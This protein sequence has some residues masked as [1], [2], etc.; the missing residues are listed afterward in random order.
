MPIL[1]GRTWSLQVG[2]LDLTD[3]DFTF[4]VERSARREPNRAEI[5]IWNLNP[6]TRAIV[7]AG[8][9]VALRCG[10]D[11]D[12]PLLF[13]GDSRWVWT[14]REGPDLITTI[15]ARDGGR[16]YSEARIA[17]AYNPGTSISTI[18]EDLIADMDIGR[19]NLDEV[20]AAFQLRTG[21][22]TVPDG[23]VAAGPCRR[24]LSDL[25]RGAGLRWSVQNGALQV[26]RGG[27]PLQ[28]TAIVLAAD[29]GLL[30]VPTW[31]ERGHR[32]R[33]RRGVLTAKSLLQP[34]TE[35]GRKVRVETALVEGDFE[36][37][38]GSYAGGTR[39]NDWTAT[40]ALRPLG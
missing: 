13:R 2:S 7:E 17:R 32:T 20:A 5:K 22:T 27:T 19:G 28:A 38:A 33:G 3:L 26:Q 12:P 37:R 15:T 18:L 8:G 30:E 6:A 4:K 11:V 40:L 21:A 29:S 24:V 31:D 35:P 16:A 39:E 25:L 34:G 14:E 9:T 23:Y 36:I 10:Y 1:F